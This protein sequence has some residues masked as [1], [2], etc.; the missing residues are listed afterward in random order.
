M[1]AGILARNPEQPGVGARRRPGDL[2][3]IQLAPLLRRRCITLK[4]MA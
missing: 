4:F 2:R 1:D 3:H